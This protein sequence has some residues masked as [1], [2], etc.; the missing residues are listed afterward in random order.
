M[1]VLP[2]RFSNIAECAVESPPLSLICANL[3]HIE[4]GIQSRFVWADRLLMDELN[5]DLAPPAKGAVLMR[6]H[7]ALQA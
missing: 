4:Y 1:D 6:V 2:S 7:H 3:L 5:K